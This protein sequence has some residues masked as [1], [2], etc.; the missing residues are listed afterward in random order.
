MISVQRLQY[1]PQPLMAIVLL[2]PHILVILDFS[3]LIQRQRDEAVDGFARVQHTRGVFLLLLVDDLRGRGFD[4][5]GHEGFGG[6]HDFGDAWEGIRQTRTK[7]DVDRINI[8]RFK[9]IPYH[10]PAI[11]YLVSQ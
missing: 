8:E 6:G 9:Y 5:L 4:D 2:V 10:C 7:Y 3:V 11:L 1:L